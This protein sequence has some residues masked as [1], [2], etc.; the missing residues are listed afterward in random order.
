MKR[1][2]VSQASNQFSDLVDQVSGEGITVELERDDKVV[3]R[4]CPANGPSVK[5]S[6]LNRLFANLPRLGDEAESFARDLERIRQE[7]PTE[8][9]RWD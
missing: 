3:A 1:I 2:S 7:P 4:L 5:V 8:S 6:D 9:D